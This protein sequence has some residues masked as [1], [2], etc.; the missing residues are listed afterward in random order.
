[1]NTYIYTYIS[2][3]IYM[4]IYVCIYIYNMYAFVQMYVCVLYM[5]TGLVVWCCRVYSEV[6]AT[7]SLVAST[8]PITPYWPPLLCLWSAMLWI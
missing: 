3:H 5:Y 8:L 4:C 6:K 7:L 1:M 2:I